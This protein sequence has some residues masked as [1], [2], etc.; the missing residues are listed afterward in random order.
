MLDVIVIGGGP[1]GI[2]AA[3]TL[4]R[5]HRPTLLFDSGVYRN[6]GVGHLHN[7]ATHDGRPP[8][9]FRKL[10]RRDLAGYDSV[11]VR[12]VRADAVERAAAGFRVTADG[13]TFEGRAVILA[14]GLRDDLPDI[15]GVGEVWG[16]EVVHCP[17]CHGHEFAGRRVVLALEGEHRRIL[18]AM[19]RRIGVEIVES[20]SPVVGVE[21]ARGGLRVHLAAGDRLDVDGMF[22]A[23]RTSAGSR[24][25]EQLGGEILVDGC[26]AIDGSGRTGVPHL[27]AAGDAAR[28]SELP[29]QRADVLV[30]AASGLIAASTCDHDLVV[31]ELSD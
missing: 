22:V 18:A 13:T 15:P 12:D 14:T 1:A 2:Q 7:F 21:L 26:V 11:S 16:R 8:D 17:Y 27:Y 24:F 25:A 4:G 6:A 28:A 20:S 19:L 23:A 30:A 10:G 29:V 5:V 9:E 3:L 31:E